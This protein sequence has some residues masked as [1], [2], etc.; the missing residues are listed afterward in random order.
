VKPA[1]AGRDAGPQLP[2][3]IEQLQHVGVLFA[4]FALLYLLA[5]DENSERRETLALGA[6]GPETSALSDST[7][8]E[9]LPQLSDGPFLDQNATRY[10]P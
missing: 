10:Q 2:F 6:S 1:T 7:V 9:V 5:M 4:D 3:E 8:A